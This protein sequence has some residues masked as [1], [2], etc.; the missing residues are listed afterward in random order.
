MINMFREFSNKIF[1]NRKFL[2]FLIAINVFG[3]F[4]GTYYYYPQLSETPLYL[5]VVVLDC[6][7]AVLLFAIVCAL[8]YLKVEVPK[9]LEFFTSAYIIKYGI[10]TLLAITLYWNYYVT[11]ETLGILTFLLHVG[12]VLEGAVLIPRISPSKHNTVIVLL[13]LLANDFFDYFL[14]TVTRIP[15]TYMGFLMY[16]SF[17]ASVLITLLIF[18]YQNKRS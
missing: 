10:W 9:I 18:I 1:S 11:N 3:F 6:P 12:M 7:I 4:A 17:A 16:E 15:E 14:G 8:I 2:L 13:L 5:W